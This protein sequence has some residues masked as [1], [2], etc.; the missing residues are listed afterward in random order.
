LA[1]RYCFAILP[2]MA[3][4]EDADD[5]ERFD[6]GA[7]AEWRFFTDQVM[8]GVSTGSVTLLS[9]GRRSASPA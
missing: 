9:E 8:G 5:P 4:A 6:P 1:W 3:L 2:G 7:D